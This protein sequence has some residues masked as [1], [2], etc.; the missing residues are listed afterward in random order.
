MT[1]ASACAP[2]SA[3]TGVFTLRNRAVIGFVSLLLFAPTALLAVAFRPAVA[4][5]VLAGCAGALALIVQPRRAESV[6]LLDQ[7]IDTPRLALSIALAGLLLILGGEMHL[8]YAT[9]DWRIRDSVL[10][11]LTHNGFPLLYAV[12]GSEYLL[13]APLGMYMLPAAFGK[14]F[15]LSAAH[16]AMWAQNSLLLGSIFYLLG[17]LGRG[18]AHVLVMILFAGF[19]L[20]G[21]WYFWLLGGTA[22]TD[23]ILNFSLDSWHPY[24]QYSSSIVQFFW[25]PNHA[26]PGWWL[27]TLLLLQTRDEVDNATVAVSIAGAVFWSPL[28]VLSVALWLV[29]VVLL[30]ARRSLTSARLWQAAAAGACILPVALYMVLGASTIRHGVTAAK[31]YFA[32][33]YM[34]FMVSNLFQAT[35]VVALRAYA[36]PRLMPLFAF[37]LC[38]LAALPFFNFGPSNDLVMR[39]SI[40]SLVIIAFAFGAVLLHPDNFRRPAFYLGLALIVACSPSA[41]LELYRLTTDQ[42]YAISDCT[43]FESTYALGG[44]GIPEN[45]VVDRRAV[46]DW[47]VDL[48]PARRS[49]P[50]DRRCWSDLDRRRQF[51]PVL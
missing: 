50:A 2:E 23:H 10:S 36:P 38:I 42:R 11:D 15:G 12:D 19:A 44:V 46:P 47:L 16:V 13:R 29:I 14:F 17:K 20:F 25:V 30:D 27:A 22:S 6:G 45:Y 28:V 7:A 3:R 41:L 51:D 34:M 21:I 33:L 32:L 39:G 49:A 26:L 4:A 31:E 5:F 40:P 48:Q 9:Y 1:D 24:F 35:Y 8:F 37:S 43:L 18:L